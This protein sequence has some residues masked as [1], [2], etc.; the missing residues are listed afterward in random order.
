[1]KGERV[2]YSSGR[3]TGALT[4]SIVSPGLQACLGSRRDLTCAPRKL[5]REDGKNLGAHINRDILLRFSRAGTE[6]RC[7]N[8]FG[9]GD[10]FARGVVL[11][12]RFCGENIDARSSNG[13][14]VEC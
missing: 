5:A 10:Q 1:M 2:R 7:C 9:V 3:M 12:R 8:D 6:M 13:T 11:D 4:E 14:C